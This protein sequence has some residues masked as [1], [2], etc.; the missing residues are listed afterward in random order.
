MW[1]E[2]SGKPRTIEKTLVGISLLVTSLTVRTPTSVDTVI[3]RLNRR[4]PAS[5]QSA[6]LSRGKPEQDGSTTCSHGSH[7]C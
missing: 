1:S 4:A 6:F 3:K 7:C 5:I 2:A